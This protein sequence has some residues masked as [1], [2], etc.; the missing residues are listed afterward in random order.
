MVFIQEKEQAGISFWDARTTVL[1]LYID[2]NDAVLEK[3]S[4]LGS[5]ILY[6]KSTTSDYG[7]AI[8]EIEDSEGNRISI[9]QIHRS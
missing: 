6:P 4:I 7:F 8:A 1:Y 5:T 9:S 3:A 2:D